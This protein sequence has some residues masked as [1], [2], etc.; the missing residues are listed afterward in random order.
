MVNE[1]SRCKCDSYL[2][3]MSPCWFLKILCP[4]AI[5]ALY[6][7]NSDIN[8]ILKLDDETE[9][10]VDCIVA[11]ASQLKNSRKKK[12]WNGVKELCKWFQACF[13]FVL[14]AAFGTL[15]FRGIEQT[16]WNEFIAENEARKAV[17]QNSLP[18]MDRLEE[19]ITALET[20]G[21]YDNLVTK[22]DYVYT[23][24]SQTSLWSE[25]EIFAREPSLFKNPWDINGGLYFCLS[26]ATT[27]GY[28]NFTPRTD[29]GKAMVIPYSI[30]A[31][32]S[33]IWFLK[34]N[35]R[36]FRH[37]WC[38]DSSNIIR[39]AHITI[40]CVILYLAL[41]GVVYQF[42]EEEW[43]Y[44]DSIYFS[45]VTTTTIGFGDYYPD[46]S[47]PSMAGEFI[48][49][50]VALQFFTF[51]VETVGYLL[52]WAELDEGNLE[53]GYVRDDIF[54]QEEEA[55]IELVHQRKTNRSWFV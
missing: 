19:I 35:I 50:F 18:I 9:T 7:K 44:L 39:R 6:V 43:N 51:M 49:L 38:E 14:I 2:A 28:G 11:L 13:W 1:N 8:R 54:S 21:G 30:V 25:V 31:I 20:A 27:I 52:Q 55:S 3:R 37:F 5:P 42:L 36:V 34:R 46:Y 41:T 16:P 24:Y 12:Q 29:L 22:I 10:T 32:I 53:L 17:A 4:S 33:L 48:M 45:W 47:S 15:M 26:I 40:L 23:N